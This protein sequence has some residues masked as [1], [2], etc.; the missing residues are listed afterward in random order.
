M[1][2]FDVLPGDQLE[3]SRLWELMHRSLSRYKHAEYQ[4]TALAWLKSYREAKEEYEAALERKRENDR[5]ARKR[6]KMQTVWLLSNLEIRVMEGE[7]PKEKF[8][9]IKQEIIKHERGRYEG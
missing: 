1:N 5:E 8:I 6:D 2:D 7:F 4:E 9:N 3:A